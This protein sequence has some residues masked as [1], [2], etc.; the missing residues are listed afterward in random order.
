MH[1]RQTVLFYQ[2]EASP[3]VYFYGLLAKCDQPLALLLKKTR[4]LNRAGLLCLSAFLLFP[5]LACLA[6]PGAD[7]PAANPRRHQ[8]RQLAGREDGPSDIR[9]FHGGPEVFS[10]GFALNDEARRYLDRINASGRE[11]GWILA[12]L[13]RARP[14]AHFIQ[15]QI[16]QRGLPP[17][18][19]YL[20]VVESLYKINASSR[21]GALGLWQF[22][23]GSAQPWLRIDDW[24]DERK[25]FWKSTEAALEKLA[26]N[27]RLT[28][29]WLLALAA[30]NCGLGKVRRVMKESGIADFWELSRRGLLPRE[31]RA[32]IPKL[33]ATAHFARTLRRRGA[34]TDWEAPVRWKRIRI[35]N[36][37]DIRLLAGAA[38]LPP[39]SIGAAN[40]ELRYG[41][42][43][44]PATEYYLKVRAEQAQA[45]EEAMQTHEGK[46][47]RFA[48]HT[49]AEGHTLSELAG[50]YGIPLSLLLRYN[51][52]I[53]AQALRIGS[54]LVVPMYR[55]TAPFVKKAPVSPAAAPAGSAN[56]YTV[57]KGDS[58]W[59]I[60]RRFGTTSAALA[61]LNGIAENSVLRPGMSL[62]TP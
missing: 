62:K 29:D 5:A 51:P 24:L 42:T 45:V 59:A 17:E 3:T 12:A 10:P 53:Q 30:Y 49:V 14:Y 19:F 28:G 26:Y 44:P 23:R 15:G 57:Q 33:I 46:L 39:H 36:P 22:M 60:A 61:A 37:L 52:G 8:S 31:T 58:L 47:M 35:E 41:I 2:H 11:Q 40:A 56:G 13:E 4:G 34:D 20:P 27:H 48:I 25:D 9:Q 38:G 55:D 54:R 50:H 43:P 21:S 16:A 7:A 1:G 18:I 32:Y 6:A